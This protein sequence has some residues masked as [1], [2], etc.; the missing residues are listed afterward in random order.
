M[1]R[2]KAG[3]KVREDM[4]KEK[5]ELKKILREELGLYKND[6]ELEENPPKKESFE[7]EFEAEADSSKL[8][9]VDTKKIKRWRRRQ[10]SDTLQ[11]KPAT[12]FVIDE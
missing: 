8:D 4:R 3:E 9:S 6:K 10:K 5:L 11:N 2:E 12:K 1:D 7:F